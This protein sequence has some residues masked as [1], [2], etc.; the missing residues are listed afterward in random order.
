[1]DGEFRQSASP[2]LGADRFPRSKKSERPQRFRIDR[3][4]QQQRATRHHRDRACP[5]R[6]RFAG[7]IIRERALHASAQQ[8]GAHEPGKACSFRHPHAGNRTSNPAKLRSRRAM[9]E[10]IKSVFPRSLAGYPLNPQLLHS[11]PSPVYSHQPHTSSQSR[12]TLAPRPCP[13]TISKKPSSSR[14]TSSASSATT[15]S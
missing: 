5:R 15:S 2:T 9:A 6:D 13:L 8:A 7:T 14:P 10:A 4:F 11:N 12:R 1:M 3:S